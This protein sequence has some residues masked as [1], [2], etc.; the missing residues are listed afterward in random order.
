MLAKGR[1]RGRSFFGLRVGFKGL[2]EP[3]FEVCCTAFMASE[4]NP[5]KD[6]LLWIITVALLALAIFWYKR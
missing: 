4:K 5:R 2:L 3:E 6:I 1:P